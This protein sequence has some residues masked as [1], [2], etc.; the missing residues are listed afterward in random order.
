ML[1]NKHVLVKGA[2][3]FAS[4]GIR[5][6]HLAGAKVVA[7]ELLKP[8]TIRRFASFSEAIYAG[9]HTVEGVTGVKARSEEIGEIH[10]K[11]KIPI[12][13]DPGT[14][15]INQQKFDI[16]IDARM[17]KRNLGTTAADAPIVIGLGPGFSAGHDCHAIVE[18]LAGHNLGRVI[19]NGNPAED[20][21]THI[22]TDLFQIPCCSGFTP[23]G[24]GLNV[25]NLLLRS[26]ADGMF[27]SEKRIGDI[28]QIGD[29]IGRI[30]DI[31]L[32][33]AAPGIL[34]GLIH[35]N[36]QVIKDLKVGDIDPSG[37]RDRI[38]QISEKSNAIAGGI[39]EACL[40]LLTKRI[41]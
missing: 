18:T 3:D 26:P 29:V 7:T 21:R 13:I 33:A 36:V 22:P 10:S 1:E 4:G 15:I 5:R 19:Y 23:C 16:V 2:G 34:R 37:N 8:L 40:Y 9:E 12:L 25:N 31:E 17:A 41:R 11:G 14:K 27:N 30:D 32:I 20:T 35:D 28:I 6:L 24:V 39:L 38:N